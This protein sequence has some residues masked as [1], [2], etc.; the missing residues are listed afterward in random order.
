MGPSACAQC[1]L[2]ETGR[3]RDSASPRWVRPRGR[4]LHS[5]QRQ[6][7]H[8]GAA[9]GLCGLNSRILSACPLPSS[10]SPGLR[11]A[12]TC[13]PSQPA[14]NSASTSLASSKADSA[15]EALRGLRGRGRGLVSHGGVT[16]RCNP[17]NTQLARDFMSIGAAMVSPRNVEQILPSQ[18]VE[19]S[20]LR[21]CDIPAVP[22]RTYGASVVMS[23]WAGHFDPCGYD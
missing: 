9:S 11:H 19:V 7:P 4:V 3:V 6:V 15:C 1:P 20:A 21:L 22:L 8:R 23:A 13:Q 5:G 12:H 2:V 14:Q 16:C 10:R 18:R 17:S